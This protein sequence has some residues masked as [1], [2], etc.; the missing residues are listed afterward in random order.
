M[1][2]LEIFWSFFKVGLFA[3]GGGYGLIA[4]IKQEVLAKGWL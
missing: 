4:M 3:F 2:Y 1:I